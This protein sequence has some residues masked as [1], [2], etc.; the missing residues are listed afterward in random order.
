MTIKK[1]AFSFLD[2]ILIHWVQNGGKIPVPVF[3]QL[4]H[5]NQ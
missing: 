5:K 1:K 2:G 3:S 4:R